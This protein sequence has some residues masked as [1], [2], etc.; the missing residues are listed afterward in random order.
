MGWLTGPPQRVETKAV[1]GQAFGTSLGLGV[2][3]PDYPAAG[4]LPYAEAGFG[5]NELVYACIMEKATSLPEAP[6]RVYG[7][8][9]LGEPRENHPLRELITNPNPM[10]TEFEL[11]ELTVIHMDLAGIA[12]WEIIRDQAGRPVQLWPLRPDLVRFI[13]Q[14]NGRTR[15]GYLLGGSIVDLGTDVLAFRYPN[16]VDPLVGQAPLRPALRA[17]ALDNEATDFVKHLL[18]NRAVPG[19]VITTQRKVDQEVSDRLATKW[20]QKFGG[21]KRGEPAVLQ[22]GMDVKVLGLDLNSLE[23]PDL[24]TIS[25]ARICSAFGVPPILVGAKVGLDRSTFANYKEARTSF[26]EETILPLQRRIG[27][28]ITARLLPEVLDAQFAMPRKV[29]VRWDRSQVLALK[30]SE[31]AIWERANNALRSGAI[32]V[33]EFRKIVGLPPDPGADVYLRP[34]G[35][36]PTLADGTP[37]GG[38][39]PAAGTDGGGQDGGQEETGPEGAALSDAELARFLTASLPRRP[40]RG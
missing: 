39:E 13:R 28:V 32:T 37:T 8:D 3:S 11:F 12:F 29:T 30:E 2:N 33:N 19:V 35:V 26:W 14:R 27:D 10:L 25:E 16:P 24:R 34:A 9:G 7:P 21:S 38:G 4:F 5:R 18:Q 22:A 20:K 40:L 15:Y 17:V 6:L 23:F 1:E 31:Q 36:T